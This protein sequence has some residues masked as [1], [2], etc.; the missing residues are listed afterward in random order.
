[1]FDVLH[2]SP[3][4]SQAPSSSVVLLAQ[5][6]AST[7][8]SEPSQSGTLTLLIIRWC[9]FQLLTIRETVRHICAYTFFFCR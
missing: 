3:S 5:P 9:L 1:M 8:S 4:F 7:S 6:T 2:R